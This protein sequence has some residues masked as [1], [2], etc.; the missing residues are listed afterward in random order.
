LDW[1]LPVF[2]EQGY[3]DP[4]KDLLGWLFFLLWAAGLVLLVRRM[5][6]Y[7]P[8]WGPRQTGM[9]TGAAVFALL[10]SFTFGTRLPALGALPLP[11]LPVSPTGPLL[12]FF[13]VVP[14]VIAA[15]FL[16][17]AAA[18]LAGISGLVI[19][20]FG[21]HSP[22]LPLEMALLGAILGGLLRQA[23]RTPFFRIARH[24]LA[25]V[26]ILWLF[27][28][29]IFILNTMFMVG[30]TVATRLDYAVTNL[31]PAM[32]G[33]GIQL[34]VAGLVGQALALAHPPGWG[35]PGKLVPSPVERS[36]AGRFFYSM[37]LVAFGLLVAL[38]I[39]DWIVAERAARDMLEFRMV[40]A[41]RAAADGVP[42][43][44]E[45]GQDLILQMTTDELLYSASPE[46]LPDILAGRLRT[47][48]YF[49]QL[50]VF[51]RGAQFVAGYPENSYDPGAAPADEATGIA[52]A[53]QGVRIQSYAIPAPQASPA[54]AWVSFLASI[55]DETG[56]VRGALVGRVD[57]AAN[58]FT[59]PILA[60]LQSMAAVQGQGYLIDEQGR[61][62]Y[63][64]E[65]GPL[66]GLYS[67]RMDQTR[68]FFDETAPDGTRNLTYYRQA[69]GRPWAV[70][71]SVPARY[72]QS[73][74]IQIAVPLLGT[75]FILSILAVIILRLGLRT[76]TASLQNLAI[77]TERIA[78]GQLDHALQVDGVD[79]VGILRRSFEKMRLSLKAR[80]EELNRLLMVSQGVASSLEVQTAIQPVLEAA[81]ATGASAVRIVLDST[82]LPATDQ[83][84]SPAQLRFGAGEAST[85]FAYLDEQILA[86]TREQEQVILT[87]PTRVRMLSFRSGDIRPQALAAIAL[88]YEN[89]YYGALWV[90]YEWSR[91]FSDEEIRYMRTLASQAA[92]AVSNARLFQTAEVGRQRLAAILASTPDAVLV[93]DHQNRL[94]LANPAAWQSLNA[95]TP[96]AAGAS[97][98]QLGLPADLAELMLISGE[99]KQSVEVLMPN[100][101][102]YLA[103][104]SSIPMN[105]RH[106]GRVCVLR[107]VTHFKELDSLKSEFVSTVSHDLRSP[108]TL[109]RGYATMLQMVGELNDQ[110][111]NYVNKIVI[112]IENMSRLVNNLLD[113]GRIEAGVGLQL[114]LVPVQDVVEQVAGALQ[115]Q[116]AQKQIELSTRFPSGNNILVEADQALLQQAIHNLVENA[117]KY[118][119]AG[120][121]VEVQ[122]ERR[123]ET[124]LVIV[125]DTGIGIAPIDQSRL[126]EKFFR[127]AR[128]GA[129]QQRGTG[130]GL[131]IV[132][133]IAERHGGRVWVESQLGK[134]SKFFFSIP[135]RQAENAGL[136]PQAWIKK[137]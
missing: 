22:F 135:L 18:V 125:R 68:T 103:I 28:P 92:L 110:Q 64:S 21:S 136:A 7:L 109:I 6:H 35:A 61:V 94:L 76:V 31:T 89:R 3:F 108:L 56:Q 58:P 122:V 114:E 119:E 102:V 99:E 11:N 9:L 131:A 36:L 48:P 1:L 20:Y 86:L 71:I 123:Q 95:E 115:L 10:A 130:L 104:A 50:Y 83:A 40:N 85:V 113:L 129:M 54:A 87:N 34:L 4:P 90:A 74:A 30:G 43:F 100:E 39:G 127:V 72:T 57:L 49:N 77:E 121:Q 78:Q 67:G 26:S 118:T 81:Q 47:V 69:I 124:M 93:T 75:L 42:F 37:G 51:D 79:E 38:V 128:R 106:I 65:A 32:A 13:A 112:G 107:D 73:L 97:L 8:A 117:L 25:A 46:G 45:A 23:F 2:G 27:Y 66:M 137:S 111:T 126:F 84:A 80:L 70:A 15:G 55:L 88:H 16:G 91:Q 19:G 12:M 63:D 132:K 5:R 53:V 33:L 98:D 60:S 96:L 101:R 29:V 41:A 62:L 134:G 44:L 82:A 105:N 133:S 59:Q 116:A 52:L 24:P 17:P 120:G 14:W